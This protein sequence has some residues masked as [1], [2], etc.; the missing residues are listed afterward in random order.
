MSTSALLQDLGLP[1]Q[2]RENLLPA[3]RAH[4]AA[5]PT[6]VVV[7]D[8]DL[9][10]TQTVDNIPVLTEWSRESL[11]AALRAPGTGFYILAN[12]RAL[13]VRR[14]LVRGQV[15]PGIPVWQLGPESRFPGMNCIVFAGKE[16]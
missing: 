2:W 12:S 14:V 11:A 4:L 10:G 5:H 8:D 16:G 7:L 9:T 1:P 6:K 13:G 15:L 3:I